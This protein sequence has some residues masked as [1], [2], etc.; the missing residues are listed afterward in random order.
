MTAALVDQNELSSLRIEQSQLIALLKNKE[1][2][3]KAKI[4]RL[5]E[6]YERRLNLA[7][8]D[9][10]PFLTVNQIST[11]I[12]N[13][14]R[15]HRMAIADDVHHYLPDKYKNPNKQNFLPEDSRTTS[16]NWGGV[17]PTLLIDE[18]SQL[19]AE[20][21]KKLPS[22]IK[23]MLYDT[24]MKNKNLIES[25]ALEQHYQL[26]DKEL[27]ERIA[28]SHP[29]KPRIT[30]F[31]TALIELGK[32]ISDFGKWINEDYPPPEEME[33]PWADAVVT[34][35]SLWKN[36]CNVKRSLTDGEWLERD[37]YRIHQSKH[38]AAVKD[39]VETLLCKECSVLNREKYIPGDFV[40]MVYD[41]NSPSH[42]RCE[43]CN[44]TE[45]VLRGLTREQCGD[46]AIQSCP[47]LEDDGV[48]VCGGK[49]A[50]QCIKCGWH[51]KWEQ[52]ISP[53]ENRAIELMSQL[54]IW[55]NAIVPFVKA[56][57]GKCTAGR[58]VKL[59]VDLSR[60]A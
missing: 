39:K 32:T 31:G 33:Q 2:S 48:T 25:D 49:I 27:R 53:I 23:I 19:P 44:G 59:G 30:R 4:N 14:L 24:I 12:A 58:K 15:T 29:L 38:G 20:E 5:A 11:E 51:T 50:L 42:W 9:I 52:G 16:R 36:A 1:G 40:E 60:Q 57:P 46:I 35:C 43:E 18:L 45:G 37:T 10:S 8:P 26:N 54:D 56:L 22:S 41:R 21:I 34:Y 6:I 55:E 7:D 28:N 13:V 17:D 47:Q 3:L